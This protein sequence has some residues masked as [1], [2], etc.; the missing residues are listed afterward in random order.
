MRYKLELSHGGLCVLL[1]LTVAIF[2]AHARPAQAIWI[3]FTEEE[4]LL[5]AFSGE[6]RVVQIPLETVINPKKRLDTEKKLGY[7]LV[8][9]YMKCFQGSKDGIVTGYACIDNVI[10]RY[11]PI[12]F[13]IKFNFPGAG[14]AWYEVMVYREAIGHGVRRGPFREQFLGKTKSD[15]MKY[16]VDVRMIA[17][18]TLSSDHLLRAFRKHIYMYHYIFQELAVLPEPAEGS[19]EEMK[20]QEYIR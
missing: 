11:R 2:A 13:M 14:I 5:V 19:I 6:E 9:P 10:G 20:I 16:G 1:V 17:G 7:A 15:P 18:A 12:T 8:L 4:V 3:Y